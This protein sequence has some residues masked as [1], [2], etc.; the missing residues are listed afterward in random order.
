MKYIFWIAWI[1]D[2]GVAAWWVLSDLKLEYIKPNPYSFVFLIYVI[3][4]LL[5]YLLSAHTKTAMIMT[6]IPAIPLIIMTFV[7]IIAT[8]T[9]AKWN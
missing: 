3:A 4:A 8:L 2:A 5:I 1:I 9:G 6:L 7:A